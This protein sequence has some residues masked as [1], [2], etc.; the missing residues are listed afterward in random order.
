ME[1]IWTKKASKNLDDLE[2]YITQDNPIAAAKI[3]LKVVRTVSLLKEHPGMGKPGRIIGTRELVIS[4]TPYIVPYRV[5]GHQIEI[6][7]VFHSAMQW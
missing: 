5:K 6:L 3:V 4:A 1:I 7:R 2:Q